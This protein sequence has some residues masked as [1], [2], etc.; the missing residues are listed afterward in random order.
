MISLT[1][2]EKRLRDFLASL[3]AQAD[4][5]DPEASIITYGVL[6]QKLDPDDDLGWRQG[7]GH[8][9]LRTALYHVSVYEA[10]H[11]R[12]L[13]GA[14]AVREG[15]IPGFG[16]ADIGRQLN[17]FTGESKDAENRFWKSE[18]DASVRHWSADG[19]QAAALLDPQFDALKAENAKLKQML[20]TLLHG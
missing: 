17:L 14:F 7:P 12:P 5:A 13:L 9:R 4:P 11:G 8:N 16:F 15:G 20:R 3:A 18:L 1:P 6:G 2:A 10:Q 19:A